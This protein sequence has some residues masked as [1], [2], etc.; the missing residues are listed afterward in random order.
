ML[1]VINLGNTPQYLERIKPSKKYHGTLKKKENNW[2][3][4]A[5]PQ[6]MNLFRRLFDAT[7]DDEKGIATI[8][9]TKR[10]T[11]ELNWFMMCY[12]LKIISFN[13]WDKEINTS[14]KLILRQ[15]ILNTKF[16]IEKAPMEFKGK[17]MGFQEGG[18]AFLYH[19]KRCLLADEMGLGKTV[20]ALAYISKN[21]KYPVLVV[22][23]PHIL[24]QWNSEIKKFLG[25]EIK[26]N[27]INGLT[28][29]T[30]P[31]CNIYLIHY[32]LLRGWFQDLSAFEFDT[33]IFD[34]VQELR[35]S[36]SHKYRSVRKLVESAKNILGLSGTPIYNYGFEIFNVLNII[37]EGCLVR[38]C[39]RTL[40]G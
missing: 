12:P 9:C 36:T 33:I 39:A 5:E 11:S 10:Y 20:E 22:V 24:Y 17:L 28:P 35:H 15:Q 26:T 37:D 4:E 13:E 27:I 23:P 21:N 38:G 8:P 18:L 1:K 14:R 40:A 34:E 25:N 30:L 7:R 6:A 3:I 19:N 31:D 16:T 2:I 32:L 29:Y